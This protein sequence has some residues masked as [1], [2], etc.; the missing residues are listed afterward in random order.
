MCSDCVHVSS[1]CEPGL[2]IQ[3]LQWS[4]HCSL[5]S[6]KLGELNVF[7]IDVEFFSPL[8]IILFKLFPFCTKYCFSET[9]FSLSLTPTCSEVPK[10]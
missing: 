4:A 10:C 3:I 1:L 9:A 7:R 8:N 2:Q 6:S 5:C